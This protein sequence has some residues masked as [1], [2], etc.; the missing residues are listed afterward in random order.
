MGMGHAAYNGYVLEASKD[1]F[2]RLQLYL[3]K[4]QQGMVTDIN[5]QDDL[6]AVYKRLHEEDSSF[7]SSSLQE[8]LEVELYRYH[9]D[10][11]DIYDNLEDGYYFVFGDSD[12]FILT[13]TKLGEELK[14]LDCFP[15]NKYWTV[16]G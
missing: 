6:E 1:N 15:E 8:G 10:E 13:P 11:G 16:Y 14:R 4:E 9:T 5:I 2:N 3:S 7:I 12:L